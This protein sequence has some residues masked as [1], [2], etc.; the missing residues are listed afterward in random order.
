M[1]RSR[2]PITQILSIHPPRIIRPTS[3]IPILIPLM[4]TLN[5]A[6]PKPRSLRTISNH[7]LNTPLR[8]PLIPLL[9]IMSLH[10]SRILD[11]IRCWRQRR[12]IPHIAP[13]FLHY[14]AEDH[15]GVNAGFV[16]DDGDPFLDVEY[17]CGRGVEEHESFVD[18]E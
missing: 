10:Q 16:G 11:K 6:I 1:T 9:P 7:P 3:M 14:D 2:N 17:F 4:P 5:Q 12:W 15:A 8:I 13:R 18:V